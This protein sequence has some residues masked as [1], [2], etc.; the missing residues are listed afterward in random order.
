MQEKQLLDQR[1]QRLYI[2]ILEWERG[3]GNKQERRNECKK[4]GTNLKE[5]G[6]GHLVGTSTQNFG[7]A[8]CGDT[9]YI[10]NVLTHSTEVG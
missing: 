9:L 7:G 4:K 10:W 1:I 5:M 6:N 2:K 3:V 8:L